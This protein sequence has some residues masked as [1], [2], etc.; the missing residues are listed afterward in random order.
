MKKKPLDSNKNSYKWK[1]IS[2]L[3]LFL[4]T[5]L[6]AFSLVRMSL[7]SQEVPPINYSD[8]SSI[9]YK[10]YL[11]DNDFYTEK[12]LDMGRTYIASLIDYIDVDFEYIFNIDDLLTMDFD[13]EVLGKLVIENSKGKV[14]LEKDYSL[15]KLNRKT[16]TAS[17]EIVITD[18]IKIDYDRY[19]EIANTFRASYGVETNS[20][21]KFYLSVNK[22]GKTK[23]YELKE[24]T[25]TDGIII[26]LAQRAIEINSNSVNNINHKQ[27]IPKVKV[28]LNTP[29]FIIA[30]ILFLISS[31]FLIKIIMYV[32]RQNNSI[33]KYDKY[34]NKLL[35]EYDR[36]IVEVNTNI[37]LEDYN[38]I[39]VTKF[40]ELLDVRDNL[41]L[42][43]NYK[44]IVKHE[45]G[46][47]YIKN[48]NDVYLF[49]VDN[50]IKR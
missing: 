37:D 42:P 40:S 4:Y 20:Y 46:I 38:V 2:Y 32:T 34:V 21:L 19:N 43:I 24:K 1:I 36:L 48:D 18:N 15:S 47:F 31:Y 35:K 14:F 29:Y 6:F 7:R 33:S 5:T 23:L 49:N 50:N 13:Y 26:P 3:V 41:K 28:T 9:N 22:N 16:M 25:N 8:K 45:K 17:N 44:N 30:T 12:Y 10:V 11:K 39:H 27:I